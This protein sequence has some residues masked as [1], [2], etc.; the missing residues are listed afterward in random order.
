MP[1]RIISHSLTNTSL[2]VFTFKADKNEIILF[3]PSLTELI[4]KSDN[5]EEK[6]FHFTINIKG[7]DNVTLG[8]CRF[9][10]GGGW[11]NVKL[12]TKESPESIIF[13]Y[14]KKRKK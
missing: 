14:I 2:I 1:Y 5:N 3:A 9:P 12:P 8:H 10:R 4:R 6:L 11:G 7:D 13:E